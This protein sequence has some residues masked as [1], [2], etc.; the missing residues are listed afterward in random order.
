[1]SKKSIASRLS[2]KTGK[3]MSES[4]E[5]VEHFFDALREECNSNSLLVVK[6]F[7]TFSAKTTKERN[8]CNPKTGEKLIIKGKKQVK[9]RQSQAFFANT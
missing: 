3:T 6:G 1:M 7:G 2:R 8:G 5:I 4:L 9:F